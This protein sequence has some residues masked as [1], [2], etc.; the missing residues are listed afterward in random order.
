MVFMIMILVIEIALVVVIIAGA[1]KTFAKAGEPGWAVLIPIYNTIVFL[2]I[3]GKPIWWILLLMIP[4]VGIVFAIM[5]CIDFAK[6]FGK[7]A[8]F[9]IG[10]VLLGF[11][12]FPIL[13]FGSA[14]YIGV[15][16]SA[17]RGKKKRRSRDDDYDDEEDD[18][19]DDRDSRRRK[20]S[21]AK[22]RIEDD[23][24][25]FEEEEPPRKVSSVKAAPPPPP[26]PKKPAAPVVAASDA[27]IVQCSG[28]Q[29]K[30]KVP[31]TAVGKK[32]KCP[33]CGTAFVA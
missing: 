7:G 29:K 5:A 4:L 13:G 20:P 3:A 16:G 22:A 15:D 28:C 8:G 11:I 24:D 23:E 2:K 12:F 19:D 21:K 1:W 27:V 18:Y 31:A 17:G 25:D 30:L 9:A 32:V 26:L 6:A 33:G 10:L 14:E